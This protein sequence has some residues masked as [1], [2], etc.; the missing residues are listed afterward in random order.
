MSAVLGVRQGRQV[1]LLKEAY[2]L[3]DQLA[4]ADKRIQ[5]QLD[6]Q[7]GKLAKWIEGHPLAKWVEDKV[8]DKVEDTAL[9]GIFDGIFKLLGLSI[10]VGDAELT[11]VTGLFS[12]HNLDSPD[13]RREYYF[14][15]HPQQMVDHERKKARLR[16]IYTELFWMSPPAPI[17]LNE[18]RCAV[19]ACWQAR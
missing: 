3:T 18:N 2:Y 5:T 10:R 15:D 6:G 1:A 14:D 7:N 16:A 17:D 8:V 11:V 12:A 9:K 13:A 4:E 19:E